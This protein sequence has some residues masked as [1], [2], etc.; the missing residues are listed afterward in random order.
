MSQN[1]IAIV[2][3]YGT[4]QAD[5]IGVPTRPSRDSIVAA[6]AAHPLRNFPPVPGRTNHLD[7]GIL[8][9]IVWRA[10]PTCVL[11]ERSPTLRQ[12]A[13]EICFPGGRPEP[14]DVNLEATALR[15]A[16]EEIGIAD[17]AE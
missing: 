16:R 2:R 12:H 1:W 5:M 13:G 3:D 11:T 6:L 9:P 15:E 10:D 7:A 17:G 14:T 4:S 8:V